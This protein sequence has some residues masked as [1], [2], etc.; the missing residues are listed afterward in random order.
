[1]IYPENIETK[2]GFDQ[3]R[4]LLKKYCL[5]DLGVSFVKKLQFLTDKRLIEKHLF[6]TDDF[7]KILTSRDSF[8][9]SNYINTSASLERIK[10]EGTYLAESEM[11]D[12]GLAL[13]TIIDCVKFFQLKGESYPHLHRLSSTV[14]FDTSIQ[15]SITSKFQETGILRDNASRELSRIRS[16]INKLDQKL[17]K[18]V[19][20]ILQKARE[21]GMAPKDGSVSVRDG[22]LV[23]PVLAENKRKIKGVVQD[24]SATGQTVFIEPTEAIEVNNEISDLRY[25]ERREII[26]ILTELSAEVRPNIP[27]LLNANKF[28]GTIDF[29]RAKAKL[30]INLDA[31]LPAISDKN[32]LTLDKAKHPLLY[33]HHK[34]I[35]KEVVPLEIQLNPQQRILIISGPNAGGKSVS[36]KTVGLLQYM[37]QC[38]LLIP[39]SEASEMMVFQDLFIDIGDE[40]S[41]ENDLS[42]YSSHLKNLQHF[43]ANAGKRSLFLI[44]EFGTG[45]EPQFGGAIAE[46]V[47]FQLNQLKSFGVVTTHYSNLKK[48]AENSDGIENAAMKFDMQKLR[49]LYQ[50]E[51]GKPGSSFALEIAKSIGFSPELINRAKE[52][53]GHSL[54]NFD[55]L[56]NELESEKGQY[57]AKLEQM[58]KREKWLENEI[59]DYKDLKGDIEDRQKTIIASARREAEN[60]ISQ[61]NKKIEKTIREIRE[62]NADKEKTREARKGLQTH[63]SQIKQKEKVEKTE[64]KSVK[65]PSVGDSVKLIGQDSTGE[66][67][68]IKGKKAEVLTGSIK[69]LVDLSKLEVLGK[70]EG[71]SYNRIAQ[72]KGINYL[73]RAVDFSTNL[74]LRGKRAE[75]AVSCL[76]PFLDEALLLG[77]TELRIIHGKGDGILRQVI[78]NYLRGY[79]YIEGIKDEHVEQGGAGVS[80]ITLK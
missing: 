52:I 75:E 44:D 36:L 56:V 18:V 42:T 5:S 31:S 23:L 53:A 64:V 60:L 4:E 2:L 12:L 55:T 3:I 43:L 41:I 79:D 68:K 62:T 24:E 25:R 15:R 72:V 80:V 57:K 54:V 73:Q 47:L 69:S 45:T 22:R 27:A 40:Q 48:M 9:S 17:R 59:Q 50:L 8:P 33:L 38:G 65:T 71:K 76:D 70:S 46:V 78:R 51:I 1:L 6:Q 19:H 39:A 66:V 58:T 30:S 10:V 37:F 32:Q 35:G 21:D 34:Q 61:T 63:L 20:S 11:F 29:I 28:L 13:Q 26:N 67:L 16:D 14:D 49:P 74:D 7:R 77:K